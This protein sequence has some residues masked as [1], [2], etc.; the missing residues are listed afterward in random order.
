MHG[1][2]HKGRDLEATGCGFLSADLSRC[3]NC[4]TDTRTHARKHKHT[5][6]AHDAMHTNG[7]HAHT[8]LHGLL[9]QHTA[10]PSD[11]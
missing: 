8:I 6:H 9:L 10:A 2:A 7:R 1:S 11:V 4:Q 5:L 3:G